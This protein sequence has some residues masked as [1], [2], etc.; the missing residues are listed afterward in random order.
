MRREDEGKELTALI[1]I[2]TGSINAHLLAATVPFTGLLVQRLSLSDRH[3]AMKKLYV[4]T[5]QCIGSKGAFLCNR[6]EQAQTILK[7]RKFVSSWMWPSPSIHR[8]RLMPK[9]TSP[10]DS[11]LLITKFFENVPIRMWDLLSF[12]SK[13]RPYSVQWLVSR[14]PDLETSRTRTTNSNLMSS[15]GRPWSHRKS[16]QIVACSVWGLEISFSISS[17]LSLMDGPFS[18]RWP[19]IGFPTVLTLTSMISLSLVV[20][21]RERLRPKYTWSLEDAHDQLGAM[22][23][24]EELA[25]FSQVHVSGTAWSLLHHK[26]RSKSRLQ[27]PA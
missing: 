26:K 2:V 4:R 6:C 8:R 9:A 24:V 16:V 5:Y 25:H 13:M 1:G 3:F 15:G 11:P 18:K 20:A 21:E 27:W 12:S 7:V 17:I 19:A 23:G 14:D 22:K 10:S